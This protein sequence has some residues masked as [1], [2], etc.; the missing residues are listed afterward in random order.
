M[1]NKEKGKGKGADHRAAGNTK[2]I[3]FITLVQSLKGPWQGSTWELS[4]GWRIPYLN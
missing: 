4:E 3:P 1:V 2:I